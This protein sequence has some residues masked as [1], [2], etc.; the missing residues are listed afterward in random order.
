M[1]AVQRLQGPERVPPAQLQ[2][3]R[4]VVEHP[5][6][7]REVALPQHRPQRLGGQRPVLVVAY[8]QLRV[9][10]QDGAGADQHRVAQGT[11]RVGVT[12]GG[13]AADPPAGAVDGG[14]APVQRGGELPGHEGPTVLV[15]ERPGTVQVARVLLE[16]PLVDGDAG[17][18]QRLQ[19]ALRHRVGVLLRDHHPGHARLDQRACARSGPAGVVA[20][21]EG[22][23]RGRAPGPLARGP[24]G[25]DLGVRRPGTLVV[26][27]PTVVPSGA[28]STQPTRGFG[29]NGTPGDAASARARRIASYSPV[30]V[31]FTSMS[32]PL[33]RPDRLRGE[34][35]Y[36]VRW[37]G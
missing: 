9:V 21:L 36:G 6:A 8:G 19:T 32:S 26:S 13:R 37:L 27:L 28:R 30:K 34:G 23:H 5:A 10:G 1:V 33:L 24:Q 16:E 20:G 15:G 7:R 25:G 35:T 12:T 29:C 11:Q 18:G 3:R 2:G 22:D 31:V 17:S 14:A 4:R